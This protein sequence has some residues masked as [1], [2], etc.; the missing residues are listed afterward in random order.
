MV[1]WP[2]ELNAFAWRCYLGP[3]Y[4]S[5]DVPAYAAPARAADL[6]G[7]APAYIHVGGLDGFVHECLDYAARLLAAGV[8]VELHVLP[9]VPHGFDLVAPDAAVTRTAT[10][11][12][13]AAL[14]RVLS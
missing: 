5:D 10:A 7:L 3:L 1:I 4:G 2:R 12:S 9:S 14:A 8:S 11:L 6:A 13:D